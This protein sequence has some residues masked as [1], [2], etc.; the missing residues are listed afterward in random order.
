MTETSEQLILTLIFSFV[1]FV[2][3][4]SL[5]T[6]FINHK[7]GLKNQFQIFKKRLDIN[8]DTEYLLTTLKKLNGYKRIIKYN[9]LFI[10]FHEKGVWII[11]SIKYSNRV[12]GNFNDELLTNKVDLEDIQQ[13]PNFFLELDKL[14]NKIQKQINVS[15]NK[16]IIK[17]AIC[18]LEVETPLDYTIISKT[19]CLYTLNKIIKE[20]KKIY[21]KEDIKNMI[22]KIH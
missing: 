1:I 4:G 13:I 14:T 5:I 3:V 15:V 12:I 22:E 7:K 2:V 20:N 18:F 11:N 17:K 6:L 21:S 10:L 19:D 9:D 8:Y 16:V